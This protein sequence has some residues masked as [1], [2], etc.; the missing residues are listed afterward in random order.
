MVVCPQGGRDEM[1]KGKKGR[2][3]RRGIGGFLW[4]GK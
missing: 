2:K 4:D 1:E 3:Q